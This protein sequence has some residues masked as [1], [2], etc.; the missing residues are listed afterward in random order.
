MTAALVISLV[1]GTFWS[2]G[3]AYLHVS[4]L[5]ANTAFLAS[6][7]LGNGINFGI[8][9]LARYVEE[10]RKGKDNRTALEIATKATAPATAVGALACGLSYGS[11]DAD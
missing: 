2:F 7:L 6:I 3:L 5:N 4:Y 1:M 10:R 9:Y 11:F 8:I